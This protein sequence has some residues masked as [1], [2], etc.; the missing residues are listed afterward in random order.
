MNDTSQPTPEPLT[1]TAADGFELGATRYPAA[2]EPRGRIVIANATGVP[3]GFY[4]RFAAFA[5]ARGLEATTLDY[6]G[7]GRSA[8]KRLAGF[9]MDY[10]DWARLDLAAAIENIAEDGLAL[11]LVGHSYGGHALGLLP[12]HQRL[13]A[14]A[15][16]ACGA[17]WHGWMPWYER[18]RVRALWNVLGPVLTRWKGYLPFSLLGLGEDLPLPVYRQ[19]RRWCSYPNYF[20]GDP[21]LAGQLTGFAEVTCPILAVNASD[22]GWSPPASR[23]AFIRN[24]TGA[25][26]HPVD[27]DPATIGA[28]SI[29]HMG[30]FRAHAQPLWGAMIDWLENPSR[31]FE[32]A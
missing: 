12:N 21:D 9:E 7:T 8:P 3:Q 1:L 24:Y 23:D 25:P 15:F 16:C 10:L 5:Q 11:Y 18:I 4:R 27:L 20:F 29:G 14:A 19:W 6:R 13:A 28:K 22:D 30:Y 26:R 17:G 32:L 31:P 2:G